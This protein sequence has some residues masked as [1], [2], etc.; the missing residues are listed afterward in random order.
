MATFNLNIAFSFTA[1]TAA[2]DTFN[3]GVHNLTVLGLDGDD[4]FL[5]GS[6]PIPGYNYLDGGNG[7]DSFTL[8]GG[9]SENYILGGAGNDSVFIAAG[10]QNNISGGAGNTGSESA[11]APTRH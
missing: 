1:G 10:E 7:N 2:A 6:I 5:E 9:S 4:V 11:A 8:K 3:L